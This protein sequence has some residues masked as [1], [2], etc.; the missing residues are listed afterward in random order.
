MKTKI[1]LMLVVLL[2]AFE[3]A[4]AQPYL[5]KDKLSSIVRNQYLQQ[6]FSFSQEQIENYDDALKAMIVE[7]DKLYNAP[8]TK[9]ELTK[10][11]KIIYGN[12]KSRVKHFLSTSQYVKWD[13]F[14]P[15]NEIRQYRE[16]LG[17][18]N[19]GIQKLQNIISSYKASVK[20]I[21]TSHKIY[22]DIERIEIK[23]NAYKKRNADLCLLIGNTNAL[24]FNTYYD[25]YRQAQIMHKGWPSLSFNDIKKLAV[26]RLAFEK[27]RNAILC[28]NLSENQIKKNV[29][30]VKK[31]YYNSVKKSFSPEVYANFI[32]ESDSRADFITK[33]NYKMSN[34]QLIKY[35]DVMNDRA[36]ARFT[37]KKSNLSKAEKD[38]RNNEINIQTRTK[39][40]TF[41]SPEQVDVWWRN[42]H[43]QR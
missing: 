9:L 16:Y 35:K 26:L 17:L 24:E 37:I 31:E 12:F 30:A 27:K 1:L 39:L 40:S 32:K 25:I 20:S 7:I 33:R 19:N 28:S 29:T 6:Q 5:D 23:A 4:L 43:K 21:Y 10:Q 42:L 22:T 15:T 13:K 11:E 3:S 14:N 41:L 8:A 38:R 36:V 2:S 34:T 18:D